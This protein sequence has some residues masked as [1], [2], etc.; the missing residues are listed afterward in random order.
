MVFAVETPIGS[1]FCTSALL[2]AQFGGN[3]VLGVSKA[4][5]CA[6]AAKQLGPNNFSTASASWLNARV[7]ASAH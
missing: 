1:S 6:V 3:L 5:Q 2:G 7:A 4:A